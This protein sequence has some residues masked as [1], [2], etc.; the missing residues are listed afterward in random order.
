MSPQPDGFRYAIQSPILCQRLPL[1]AHAAP[2]PMLRVREPIPCPLDEDA[3]KRD[4]RVEILVVAA[5]GAERD[6]R[7][8]RR[9]QSRRTVLGWHI[10]AP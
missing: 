2:A 8:G 9:A 4:R 10:G 1:F 3:P 6:D 7:T 5:G